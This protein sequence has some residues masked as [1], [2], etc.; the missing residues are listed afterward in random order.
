M[1]AIQNHWLP[2]RLKTKI[3]TR[4]SR[5]AHCEGQSACGK[6]LSEKHGDADQWEA[7]KELRKETV[8]ENT[9]RVRVVRKLEIRERCGIEGLE[10]L[11]EK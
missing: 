5:Q 7:K 9:T 8:G 6:A 4:S 1:E 11:F 2:E 3:M 10:I